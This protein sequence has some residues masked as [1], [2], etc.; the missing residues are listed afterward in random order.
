MHSPIEKNKYLVFLS[1]CLN[2]LM[3]PTV[4]DINVINEFIGLS[5]SIDWPVIFTNHED[6]FAEILDKD[7]LDGRLDI[8]TTLFM[9]TI[10]DD[11]YEQLVKHVERSLLWTNYKASPALT[12]MKPTHVSGVETML[13]YAPNVTLLYMAQFLEL[14][15][16][17]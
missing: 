12:V 7:P 14:I 5:R 1:E 6:G 10:D 17:I 15:T 4:E 13:K 8:L 9:F 2:S 11:Q 3:N 16:D